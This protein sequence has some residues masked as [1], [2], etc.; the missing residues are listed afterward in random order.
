MEILKFISFSLDALLST[1]KET[2][3]GYDAIGLSYDDANK[4]LEAIL[5]N[6]SD[7][8][9]YNEAVQRLKDNR[10]KENGE[11]SERVDFSDRSITISIE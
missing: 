9:K 5:N 10:M 3:S 7:R 4:D 6:A 1:I 11:K 8:A 2:K